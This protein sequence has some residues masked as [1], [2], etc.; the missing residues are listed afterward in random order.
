MPVFEYQCNECEN[1]FEILVRTKDQGISCPRCNS[2]HVLKKFSTFAYKGDTPSQSTT[3][4][5]CSTCSGGSCA[6]C[7]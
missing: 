1:L 3:S 5:G 4:S 7:H 2:A 6:T